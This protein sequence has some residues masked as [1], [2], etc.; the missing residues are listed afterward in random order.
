MNIRKS[1]VFVFLFLSSN[2]LSNSVDE[3]ETRSGYQEI[4]ARIVNYTS[5]IMTLHSKKVGSGEWVQPP[6]GKIHVLADI[7]MTVQGGLWIGPEATAVYDIKGV[8]NKN[9]RLSVTP[10]AAHHSP[11]DA[12][13]DYCLYSVEP[14]EICESEIGGMKIH[15]SGHTYSSDGTKHTFTFYLKRIEGELKITDGCTED[16]LSAGKERYVDSVATMSE[17]IK[18]NLYTHDFLLKKNNS[19][20]SLLVVGHEREEALLDFLTTAYHLG[21]VV[22]TCR[23]IKVPGLGAQEKLTLIRR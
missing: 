23:V 7:S 16:S 14:P 12:R 13:V 11:E 3:S 19:D 1:W 10:T 4:T 17:V 22:D 21:L 9:Y 5:E 6:G 2:S 18:P 15:P 20:A 8:D